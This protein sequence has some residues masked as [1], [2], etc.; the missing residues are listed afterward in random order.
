M[1]RALKV[2]GSLRLLSMER[3]NSSK[4]FAILQPRGTGSWEDRSGDGGFD[5]YV[6]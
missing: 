5:T 3:L 6:C 1:F 4:S 2:T